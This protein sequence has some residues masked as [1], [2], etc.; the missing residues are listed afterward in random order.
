[1]GKKGAKH[2]KKLKPTSLTPPNTDSETATGPNGIADGLQLTLEQ[3]APVNLIARSPFNRV[4]DVMDTATLLSRDRVEFIISR[5]LLAFAS[6][7][8]KK[9]FRSLDESAQVKRTSHEKSSISVL[10]WEL[11]PS[12]PK[13]ITN[14]PSAVIDALLRFIYPVPDPV[15]KEPGDDQTEKMLPFR[16]LAPIHDA[17][18]KYDLEYV[19]QKIIEIANSI[20]YIKSFPGPGHASLRSYA[21]ACRLGLPYD[22]KLKAARNSLCIPYKTYPA[23]GLTGEGLDE[24]DYDRYVEFHER[25]VAACEQVL[26]ISGEDAYPTGLSDVYANFVACADCSGVPSTGNV[27]RCGAARWW[28]L[29]AS[30]AL[31]K[32][33]R[34]PLDPSIF[35]ENFVVPFF[36]EAQK[37]SA[38]A[39]VVHWKWC[40][41]MPMLAM[42]IPAKVYEVYLDHDDSNSIE[43]KQ[44]EMEQ[45]SP[46]HWGYDT[47]NEN[48]DMNRVFWQAS[49]PQDPVLRKL[50][51]DAYTP[52]KLFTSS[53]LKITSDVAAA[54][55][56]Q[57][58]GSSPST[59]SGPSNFS[60]PSMTTPAD[61]PTRVR[62]TQSRRSP[63][64]AVVSKEPSNSAN[65]GSKL[66]ENVHKLV[67]LL[68]LVSKQADENAKRE[69]EALR[70]K[71]RR[72][73][74]TAQTPV[75]G[76]AVMKKQRNMIDTKGKQRSTN[77]SQ[78]EELEIAAEEASDNRCGRRNGAEDGEA[79]EHRDAAN[80]MPPPSYIPPRRPRSSINTGPSEIPGVSLASNSQS[81]EKSIEPCFFASSQSIMT[82]TPRTSD[83]VSGINQNGTRQSRNCA[84]S[85]ISNGVSAASLQRTTG[86][87][88]LGMRR[89]VNSQAPSSSQGLTRD[90]PLPERQNKFK[91]P[92][93]KNRG[94]VYG[95]SASNHTSRE[96]PGTPV[97]SP[98]AQ[99][100]VE[101]PLT[102]HEGCDTKV[103]VDKDRCSSPPL[104]ADSSIDFDMDID[105]DELE[106]ACQ[107]VD[108][109]LCTTGTKHWRI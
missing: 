23:A 76:S 50:M 5:S 49:Q 98:I 106:R 62:R 40:N 47:H 54:Q 85:A 103:N 55:V 18:R 101:P 59:G 61:R 95:T 88:P 13:V 86:P 93:A 9:A 56:D 100:P 82:S 51:N 17:A 14:E 58:K 102:S 16:L 48:P 89:T 22:A 39:P 19:C 45:S 94:D 68:P 97:N 29:Y 34:A 65:T 87:P 7:Y 90:R 15:F 46:V 92:F 10:D 12:A 81:S 109:L 107:I 31:E 69:Q 52:R 78:E 67:A 6:P 91:V 108:E 53:K 64:T 77:V 83:C 4:H 21:V 8:F 73:K 24:D 35:F 1:M 104:E 2:A 25:A 28:Q 20:I 37:C 27:M 105:P 75:E 79:N 33:R 80:L 43:I 41:M 99:P 74:R 36:R 38:C 30:N 3:L 70:E 66:D 42:M 57:M 60:S 72:Q 71:R 44:E 32:L 96:L 26:A 63:G 84:A 11:D